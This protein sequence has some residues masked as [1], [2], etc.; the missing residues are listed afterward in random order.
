MFAID[1]ATAAAAQPAQAAQGTAKFWTNGVP[2]EVAPTVFDADF[3]NNLQMEILNVIINA[4][5][6]P[7]KA[8]QTQ[9]WEA[10]SAVVTGDV[11]TAS[12]TVAGILKLATLALANAGVDTATAMTPQ[13]VAKVI[14]PGAFVY[15]ADT[16]GAANTVAAAL[17]PALSAYVAGL[18]VKVSIANTNTGASTLNLNGLGAKAVQWNGRPLV[19]GELVAGKI[20]GLIYDGTQFQIEGLASISGGNPTAWWT[21]YADGRI[22]QGGYVSGPFGE[23]DQTI[24]LPIPFPNEYRGVDGTTY[25]NPDVSS[26]DYWLKGQTIPAL[27]AVSSIVVYINS[28]TGGTP[29]TG[30][31]WNARGR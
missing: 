11:P 25:S 17:T 9:L 3:M 28:G 24:V 19:G 21:I 4:G 18:S 8:S 7:S 10:I 14:Q 20:V 15:A 16:S 29:V 27:G 5:I 31:S 22:E 1:T 26:A 6:E 30:F 12:T 23:G 13:L 2:G